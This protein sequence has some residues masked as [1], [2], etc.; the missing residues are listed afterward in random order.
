VNFE[1]NH[2]QFFTAVCHEWLKLLETDEAK[3]LIIEALRYRIAVGQIKVCAFVIMPNHIHLI[4][5]IQNG[6]DLEDVQRDFLKYTAKELIALLKRKEGEGGLEKLFVGLK[7][8]TFQV[9]KRN[10]MSIDLVHEWFFN[11][12]FDYLHN[13]PCQPHWNLAE[14]P[15]DYRYSSA[16]YYEDGT[17]EFG[18]ITHYTEI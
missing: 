17:D 9:W 4:W 2:L 14:R 16:L 18:I 7:D 12:K 15:E 6:Y 5:R 11:Q 8:R 1:K 3:Q 10:S 13:N